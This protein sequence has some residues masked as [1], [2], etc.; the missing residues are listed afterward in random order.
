MEKEVIKADVN[1]HSVLAN[2]AQLYQY[3]FSEFEKG[4]W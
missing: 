2:L 1:Y 3:D 4:A